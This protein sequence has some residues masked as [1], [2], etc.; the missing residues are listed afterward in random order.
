MAETIW[1]CIIVIDYEGSLT[2]AMTNREI[3]LSIFCSTFRLF[4]VGINKVLFIVPFKHYH[5]VFIFLRVLEV[6]IVRAGC[7]G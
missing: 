3:T 5:S 2:P 1:V 4:L 7:V 6:I